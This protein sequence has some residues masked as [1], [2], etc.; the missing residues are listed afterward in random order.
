M[1]GARREAKESG[2]KG[3][4]R[5]VDITGVPDMIWQS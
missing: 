3:K 2:G 4:G 1:E 5:E